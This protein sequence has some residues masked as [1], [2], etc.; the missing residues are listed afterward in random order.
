VPP[1]TG[2]RVANVLRYGQDYHAGAP[3]SPAAVGHAPEDQLFKRVAISATLATTLLVAGTA[4]VALGHECVL[5]S[6]SA[7]GDA[8]ALHSSRWGT[9]TLTDVFGF[10]NEEVGGPALTPSQIDW[11][12][13]EALGQGIPGSWV[14]RTDKII[15]EGSKNPNLSDGKG[16][17][18]LADVYGEAI[19]GIYFAALGQPA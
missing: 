11:A 9:L 12:V 6:R 7:Q 13:N 1:R 8:G 18:H 19:V 5:A 4:G 17:D 14:V 2:S 3:T 15:G 16:L 10:I